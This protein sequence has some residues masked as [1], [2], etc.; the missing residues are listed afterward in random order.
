MNRWRQITACTMLALFVVAVP[1]N[2]FAAELSDY[3]EETQ[4]R[5]KDNKLEYDELEDLISV[6]NP[7]YKK[8]TDSIQESI[9]ALD[10]D[11]SEIEMNIEMLKREA[12]NMKDVGNMIGYQSY[13]TAA[14]SMKASMLEM[15][16]TMR[17]NYDTPTVKH[18]LNV[19]RYQLTS[20]AQMLM[21]QN[22][23]LTSN[24][25]M[26]AKAEELAEEAYRSTQ[27]QLSLNMGT[28]ADLLNAKK[29]V[30]QSLNGLAQIDAGLLQIRQTLF[31]MTGWS[32]DAN[33]EIGIVPV[34]DPQVIAGI[35]LEEDKI[36]A[37]GNNS[38][39]IDSR[40]KDTSRGTTASRLTYDRTMSEKEQKVCI[41]IEQ[42]YDTLQQK[43]I[44]SE[45]ANAAFA[46][47]EA[48]KRGDDEKYRM[49]IYGKLEY[50][51]A[52]VAYLTQKSAKEAADMALVNA[53]NDYQ[54][55]VKGILTIE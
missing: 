14:A 41:A 19:G 16:K 54:W 35:N 15:H 45:A 29:G 40:Q 38:T 6:Y 36:K 3:D 46:S 51:Q 21:S 31:M 39:L 20:V 33:P 4:E 37:I 49:G 2:S 32:Y 48:V 23:V 11:V 7:D 5:L 22:Q 1:I 25:E 42:L 18:N 30:E 26:A 13:M 24:R 52:E 43:R 10:M 55:G 44:E 50:L 27:T 28:E 34:I 8:G 17:K 47:A 53:Y 12:D 9:D